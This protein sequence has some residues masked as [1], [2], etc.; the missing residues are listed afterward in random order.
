M[1]AI[2]ATGKK[3]RDLMDLRFAKCPYFVLINEKGTITVE[4]PFCNE[5]CNVAT[6][7]VSWLHKLGV[8]K[9]IT[10]EL[11]SKART[12]LFELKIQIVLMDAEKISIQNIHKKLNI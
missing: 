10:G 5:K 9:V 3:A 4:N 8:T 6:Q 7:V 2:S 11:G 1:I 12:L